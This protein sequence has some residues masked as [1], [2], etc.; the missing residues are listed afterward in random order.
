MGARQAHP[1]VL[2]L[3][4]H[5]ITRRRDRIV[6]ALCAGTQINITGPLHPD[7]EAG[8]TKPVRCISPPCAAATMI[9]R[10]AQRCEQIVRRMIR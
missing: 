6:A 10:F 7:S 8:V 3:A 5:L 9:G 4:I 2:S 1:A